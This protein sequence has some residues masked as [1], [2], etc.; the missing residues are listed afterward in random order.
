MNRFAGD[1]ASQRRFH[2]N[3]P[4]PFA[5]WLIKC[6]LTSKG[7]DDSIR[8]EQNCSP[9]ETANKGS[10]ETRTNINIGAKGRALRRDLL[11]RYERNG[12]GD[13]VLDIAARRVEDLYNDFDKSAPYVRRDLD[14]DFADYLIECA[15]ELGRVPFTIRFTLT[16][17]PDDPGS[18]RVR[19]SLNT[20]FLYL[21]E[22]EIQ[23][24]LQMFRRSAILFAIGL[25]ILFAALSLNRFLGPERSVTANVF[26]EG[27][28]IAAW[29]SL[30]EALAIFLIEWFPHRKNVVLYRRMAHARLV[31]RSKTELELKS[32][33]ESIKNG[34]HPAR[35]PTDYQ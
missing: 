26:A 12:Q 33:E 4:F 20:Y 8:T 27:L 14:Q 21:A 2:H 6:M 3:P 9:A 24:I 13:I 15:R 31:F 11:S 29:V 23:K 16:N 10:I 7:D 34:S 25:G 18:S 19:R 32:N 17:P 30:W 28:T 5:A 1:S 35:Q 22:T